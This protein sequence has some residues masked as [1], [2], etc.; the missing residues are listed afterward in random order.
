MR[1]G[2]KPGRNAL[3][4]IGSPRGAR[5]TSN[6]LGVFLL[7]RLREY[8]VETR[9]LRIGDL[10]AVSTRGRLVATTLE[11]DS[12]VLTT[13]LYVDSLPSPVIRA[14][15]LLAARL[16][17]RTS[18]ARTQ[19]AAILNCAFPEARQAENAVSICRLFAQEAGL[20]WA[21]GLTLGMGE[22]IGGRPLSRTGATGRNVRRA[23]EL[24]AAALADGRPI[25]ESAKEL[26]SQPLMPI[27]MYLWGARFGWYMRDRRQRGGRSLGARPY[28]SCRC[29]EETR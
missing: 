3:L 12:V 19:F 13:P 2:L 28:E 23:L 10:A 21:G 24:A 11:A 5:S 6:Y 18:R 8:G 16:P 29:E 17:E 26:M 7:G 4:L 9:R 14:L 22:A 15:E 1:P 20:R 25:P 27:W